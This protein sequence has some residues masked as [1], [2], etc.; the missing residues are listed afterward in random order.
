MK[1][2][3]LG[4][5]A[6][7]ALFIATSGAIIDAPA[8]ANP[9]FPGDQ[10]DLDATQTSPNVRT[11]SGTV[12]IGAHT[13]GDFYAVIGLEVIKDA[14]GEC[15]T[16]QLLTED[17]SNLLFDAAS[18]GLTGT[19]TGTF[20]GDGGGLHDFTL[21]LT[22]APA[23]TWD[24]FNHK[25]FDN[26]TKESFGTYVLTRIEPPVEVPLPAAFPLFATGLGALGLRG[27]RRKRKDAAAA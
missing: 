10:F 23:R 7:V 13:I 24:F 26:T 4:L 1:S 14:T 20:L 22:D 12:T 6:S 3:Y 15:L 27:W 17:L 9:V 5:V 11:G 8:A 19:V 18:F 21:F 16:C 2:K 25:Q